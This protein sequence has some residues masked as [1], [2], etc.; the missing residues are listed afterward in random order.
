MTWDELQIIDRAN[1]VDI[2][3]AASGLGGLFRDVA[4]A[5]EGI[6]DVIKKH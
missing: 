2:F 6:Q 5:V 3:A 1:A 4:N